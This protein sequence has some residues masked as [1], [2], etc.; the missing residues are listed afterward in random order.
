MSRAGTTEL[1][2][3]A[4]GALFP[5]R[6]YPVA[7]IGDPGTPK[8]RT[9]RCRVSQQ[10]YVEPLYSSGLSAGVWWKPDDTFTTWAGSLYH[11]VLRFRYGYQG[12]LRNLYCDLRSGEYQIPPCEYLTVEATRYTPAQDTTGE[13]AFTADRSSMQVEGEIATESLPT[14]HP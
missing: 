14:S 7:S 2:V 4:L 10:A 3:G 6:W 1:P 11:G 12:M 8:A 9:V 5:T 13:F